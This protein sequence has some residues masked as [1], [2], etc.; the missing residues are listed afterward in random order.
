LWLDLLEDELR[1]AQRDRLDLGFAVDVVQAEPR[2]PE[3]SLDQSSDLGV[4][5]PQ[6]GVHEPQARA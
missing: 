5:T 3:R 2:S 4:S 1:A 6:H